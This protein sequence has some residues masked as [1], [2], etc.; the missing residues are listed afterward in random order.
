MA[1]SSDCSAI[2]LGSQD[3][4]VVVLNQLGQEQWRY[5]TGSW[6]NGVGISHDGTVIAA[7]TL[8]KNLYILNKE[9]RLIAK[10]TTGTTIQPRSVAVSGNGKHIA[11]ADQVA[12]YGFE[13]TVEPEV[14]PGEI[15]SPATIVTATSSPEVTL[16]TTLPKTLPPVTMK[17]VPEKTGTYSSSL[18]PFLAIAAL[19]GL[20]VLVLRKK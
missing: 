1:C 9:G 6:I 19:S 18:N 7:G 16:T 10:T 4:N 14:T 8:D 17:T 12:L 20:L 3:G 11:V 5:P 13:L 15:L 2:V